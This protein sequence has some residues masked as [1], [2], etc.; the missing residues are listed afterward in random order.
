MGLSRLS[1]TSLVGLAFLLGLAVM[2][3]YG[4]VEQLIDEAGVRDE[5]ARCDSE[6]WQE[7]MRKR[8]DG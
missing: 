3:T 1:V 8:G 2:F 4:L 6:Q 5:E 7:E